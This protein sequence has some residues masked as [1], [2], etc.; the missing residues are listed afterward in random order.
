MEWMELKIHDFEDGNRS[1]VRIIYLS[2]S[3]GRVRN[4]EFPESAEEKL[5]IF[6]NLSSPSL[7]FLR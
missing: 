3:R 6:A 4:A 2:Q 5:T 1:P 7:S